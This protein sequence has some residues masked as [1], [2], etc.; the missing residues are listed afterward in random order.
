MDTTEEISEILEDHQVNQIDSRF[1]P[2]K[3][4]KIVNQNL[5]TQFYLEKH[6]QKN[7][8]KKKSE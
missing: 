2:N 1:V 6:L 7:N 8:S 5:K 4:I 3:V